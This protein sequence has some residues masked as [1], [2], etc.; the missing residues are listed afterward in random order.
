M[1]GFNEEDVVD[2]DKDDEKSN[3]DENIQYLPDY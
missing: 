1:Q 2:F 3:N